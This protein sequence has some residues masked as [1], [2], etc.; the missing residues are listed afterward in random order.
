MTGL[1]I[2]GLL[3]VGLSILG[4]FALATA[5]CAREEA[6]D[7]LRRALEPPRNI[8]RVRAILIA[9][10]R[11]LSAQQIRD[12]E[13][14]VAEHDLRIDDERARPRPTRDLSN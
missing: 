4:T 2:V 12:A 9:H 10:R 13:A 6:T 1:G 8:E 3:L 7:R 14:L 11:H 5:S